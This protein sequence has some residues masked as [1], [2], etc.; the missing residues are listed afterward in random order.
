LLY[1]G[2]LRTLHLFFNC[3]VTFVGSSTG[4]SSP[5]ALHLWVQVQVLLLHKQSTVTM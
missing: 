3:S 1:K 2:Q 5:Q 4:T